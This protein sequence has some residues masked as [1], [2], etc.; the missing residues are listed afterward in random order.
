MVKIII[1][2][3]LT[4]V[5]IGMGW[6]LYTE[7]QEPII[8]EKAKKV[9][10]EATVVRL[11]Q[12]REAQKAYKDLKGEYADNFDSLLTSIKTDSFPVIKVI[13]DPDLAAEDSTYIVKRDTNMISMY[14]K[15]E[16]MVKKEYPEFTVQLDSLP[17]IPYGK[18][19]KFNIDAGEIESNKVTIQ[20]FEISA[21]DKILLE[22]LNEKYIDKDHSIQVGSMFEG[23]ITG[24]WE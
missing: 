20:V 17:Y 3:V 24:N 6:F 14:E 15:Y 16:G 13:G 18:G 2:V 10:Y 12:V 22:G 19:A 7:I 9:R 5:I 23:T 4:I 21:P 1:N 8:F 11:K